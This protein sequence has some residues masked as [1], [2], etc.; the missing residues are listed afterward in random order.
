MNRRF[1]F[2]LS[3]LMFSVAGTAVVLADSQADMELNAGSGRES[4]IAQGMPGEGRPPEPGEFRGE[5]RL[6]EEL[7]LTDDQVQQL[8]AIRE[9]NQPQ[10]QQLREELQTEKDKLRDMMAGTAS[11]QE[12]RTQHQRV[13]ALHEEM[14]N[15][16]FENMLAMRQVLTPEQRTRLA[17]LMEQRRDRRSEGRGDRQGGRFGRGEAIA[18]HFRT[19]WLK[20]E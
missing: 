8:Q 7:D 15:L 3:I 2:L 13:Q 11:E 1:A 6:I 4:A 18:L 10:M 9:A 5:G 19:F 14:G 20:Y 12:L 17:E 16:H